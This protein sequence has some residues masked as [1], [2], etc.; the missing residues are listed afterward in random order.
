MKRTYI[1]LSTIILST[2]TAIITYF[3]T[4]KLIWKNDSY[5]IIN[6]QTINDDITENKSDYK[7]FR[8]YNEYKEFCSDN[9][10]EENLTKK[11]FNRNS[12][13]LVM[14]NFVDKDDFTINNITINK[15]TLTIEANKITSDKNIN[16]TLLYLIALDKNVLNSNIKVNLVIDKKY[17]IN[18]DETINLSDEVKS[19]LDDTKKNEYIVTVLAQT[20]C[21]HCNNYKPTI[22]EL[23]DEYKFKYY[24]FDL[25]TL[26]K[27]DYNIITNT[28]ELNNFKGTPYTFVIKN[29]EFI[30]F[31]S[32]NRSKED[33][34]NYLKESNV[35]K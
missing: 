18:E 17:Q 34:L 30:S 14:S 22:T 10:I 25:N 28:Y 9:K 12:Y 31:N 11:D 4:I 33:T 35:I 27:T 3:V 7:I 23:Y 6:L 29:E 5:Q 2:I 1:I 15:N 20:W 21:S 32:G 26:T 19:W 8:N 16:G 24:W 13:V